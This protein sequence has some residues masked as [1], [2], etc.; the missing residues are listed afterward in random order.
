MDDS[1]RILWFAKEGCD[2]WPLVLLD[3]IAEIMNTY[4]CL[5]ILIAYSLDE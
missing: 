5:C 3:I 2:F 1:H 4:S